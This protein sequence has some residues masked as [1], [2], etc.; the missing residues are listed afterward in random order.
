MDALIAQKMF[1]ENMNMPDLPQS[2]KDENFLKGMCILAE[3]IATLKSMA[4][5]QQKILEVLL[6]RT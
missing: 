3:E 6:A 1:R 2:S 5:K 4:V